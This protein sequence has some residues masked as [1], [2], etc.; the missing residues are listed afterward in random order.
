MKECLLP[1]FRKIF[2]FKAIFLAFFQTFWKKF[3]QKLKQL[4]G[5]CYFL[6][7]VFWTF[8]QSIFSNS[9]GVFNTITFVA[10]MLKAGILTL[11]HAKMYFL[12][13]SFLEVAIFRSSRLRPATLLKKRLWHRCFLVNFAKFLR[14]PF[15]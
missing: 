6:R 12:P 4:V 15:L 7:N 14:I 8:F 2:L 10:L 5:K 13:E 1:I 11:C 3:L 9:S